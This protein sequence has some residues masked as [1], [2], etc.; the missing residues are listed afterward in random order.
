MCVATPKYRIVP[1][2]DTWCENNCVNF[3]SHCPE[4]FCTCP[5]VLFATEYV[6]RVLTIVSVFYRS[7]YCFFFFFV[8]QRT[9]H[10]N[11][12]NKRKT[13]SRR[14]LPGS[15]YRLRSEMPEKSVCLLLIVSINPTRYDLGFVQFL[16]KKKK[17]YI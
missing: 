13:R 5:W 8:F 16:W 1:G 6:Y 12:R 17:N 2:M 15:V 3:P 7:F 4:E 14:V 10:R 9:M 11:R